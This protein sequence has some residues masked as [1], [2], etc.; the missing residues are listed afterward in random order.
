MWIQQAYQKASTISIIIL[1][2]PSETNIVKCFVLCFLFVFV[3]CIV[4][5]VVYD[6]SREYTFLT[7]LGLY[8][9]NVW[10]CIDDVLTEE[11]R[12][13]VSGTTSVYKWCTVCLYHYLFVGGLMSYLRY[14]YFLPHSG[15][16]HILCCVF[17]LFFFVLCAPCCQFF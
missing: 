9:I 1:K 13:V 5:N 2:L 3:L 6:L 17:I 10:Y 14:L 12:V 16:Q 15:V 7:P 4:S 8:T 11:F